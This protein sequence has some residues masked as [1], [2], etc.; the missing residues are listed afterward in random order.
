MKYLSAASMLYSV[1]IIVSVFSAIIPAEPWRGLTNP[2]HSRKRITSGSV[3]ETSHGLVSFATAYGPP[4]LCSGTLISPQWVVTTASCMTSIGLPSGY[5]RVRIVQEYVGVSNIYLHPDYDVT[6]PYKNDIAL[7]KLKEK[8][9]P[10]S[11]IPMRTADPITMDTFVK[12]GFCMFTA[13]KTSL[14]LGSLEIEKTYCRAD[15]I[16]RRNCSEMLNEYAQLDENAICVENRCMDQDS[17]LW[18]RDEKEY[19][20][21]S[22]LTCGYNDTIYLAGILSHMHYKNQSPLVFT[23]IN[24]EGIG[25]TKTMAMEWFA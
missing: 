11:A 25:R 3:V 1:I 16:G 10:F 21:G 24:D 2:V 5:L 18:S 23:R 7:V 9:D 22:P 15:F 19:L 6:Y 8:S 17:D 12:R 14:Y 20:H 13:F 4:V